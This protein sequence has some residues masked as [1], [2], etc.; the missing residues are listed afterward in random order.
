MADSHDEKHRSK[1]KEKAALKAAQI[2]LV[3]LQRHVIEAD[4]KILVVFE[5]RDAAGKDGAIKRI[6]QHLSPRD[7]R[8][9]ALGKPSDTELRATSRKHSFPKPLVVWNP[10]TGKNHPS[11]QSN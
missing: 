5:G 3:K 6:V 7:A 2:Q 1:T 4:Q 8:V 9:V 10:K 11:G